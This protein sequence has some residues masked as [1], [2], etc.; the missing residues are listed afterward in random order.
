MYRLV[1]QFD[2]Y[3]K[4]GSSDRSRRASVCG[5]LPKEFFSDLVGSVSGTAYATVVEK[6]DTFVIQ[7]LRF[8][9]NP[10]F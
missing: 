10:N 6:F 9:K 2:I 3:Q 5:G 7:W 8:L 4:E 1:T